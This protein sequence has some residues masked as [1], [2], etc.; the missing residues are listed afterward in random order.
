MSPELRE[1]LGEC[2]NTADKLQILLED[3]RHGI[4]NC[5]SGEILET[6]RS[7]IEEAEERVRALRLKLVVLQSEQ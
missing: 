4:E 5:I 3:D 1:L 7:A 6:Y 2:L